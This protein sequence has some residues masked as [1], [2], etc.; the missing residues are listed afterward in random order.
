M[1]LG[2]SR[3]RDLLLTFQF[4]AVVIERS[5]NRIDFL[6]VPEDRPDLEATILSMTGFY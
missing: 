6:C 4:H 3:I 5:L 1:S 2:V